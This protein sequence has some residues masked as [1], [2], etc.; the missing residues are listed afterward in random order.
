[1][2]DPNKHSQSRGKAPLAHSARRTTLEQL[3]P[4]PAFVAWPF[5]FELS[6]SSLSRYFVRAVSLSICDIFVAG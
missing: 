6:A 2:I 1:M 5:V 4:T 3:I